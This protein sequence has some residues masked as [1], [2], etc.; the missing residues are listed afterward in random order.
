MEDY[1]AELGQEEVR[2]KCCS[3]ESPKARIDQL[4]VM[5]PAKTIWPM[6]LRRKGS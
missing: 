6:R 2:M 3:Q 1:S 4:P 5:E